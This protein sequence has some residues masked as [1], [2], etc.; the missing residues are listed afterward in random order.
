MIVITWFKGNMLV[1][2]DYH[3]LRTKYGYMAPSM[4][5]GVGPTS[6]LREGSCGWEGILG[7]DFFSLVGL[8]V[9]FIL[10][11]NLSMF[12]VIQ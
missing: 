1:H 2:R 11:F 12:V 9:S 7:Y 4:Q 8:H 6:W 5:F 3:E 10:V